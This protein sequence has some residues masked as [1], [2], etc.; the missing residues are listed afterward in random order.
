MV[1]PVP[2]FRIWDNAKDLANKLQSREAIELYRSVEADMA[3]LCEWRTYKSENENLFDQAMF[4]SDYCGA[5]CDGEFYSEALEKG[6]I[7]ADIIKQ[8]NFN[9][10]KYV[11]YNIGNI[12]LFQKDY[13]QARTWYEIALTGDRSSKRYA[14]Y[15]INYGISL[16]HIQ[17]TK[18]AEAA[19]RAAIEKSRGNKYRDCF[20]PYFYM[21]KIYELRHGEKESQKYRKMYLTRLKKYSRREIGFA[22]F[23]MADGEEIMNDYKNQTN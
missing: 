19:F 2:Q 23:T 17:L 6:A 14:N 13:A 7:A 21:M 1:S 18:E 22:V 5:L 10:L 9:T 12:F 8:Q 16:Y 4:F 11:Y 15:L 20:E 3:N